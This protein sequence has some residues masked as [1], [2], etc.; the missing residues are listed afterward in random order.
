[1]DEKAIR[2]YPI[3]LVV[4]LILGIWTVIGAVDAIVTAMSGNDGSGS[5]VFVYLGPAIVIAA[6]LGAYAIKRRSM[7]RNRRL[8]SR[9]PW[10]SK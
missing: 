8:P 6:G 9:L 4:I 3:I 1:M 2:K 7:G 10:S 5:N